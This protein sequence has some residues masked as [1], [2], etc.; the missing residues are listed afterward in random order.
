MT[1]EDLAVEMV[2]L[3]AEK[4]EYGPL[5]VVERI[6]KGHESY[7]DRGICPTCGRIQVDGPAY[8]RDAWLRNMGSVCFEAAA[9][10]VEFTYN[11]QGHRALY[12]VPFE[13]QPRCWA[14]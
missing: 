8:S 13:G 2:R 3:Q 10:T 14:S 4:D 1:P 6:G 9:F 5:F 12:G 7:D 11:D